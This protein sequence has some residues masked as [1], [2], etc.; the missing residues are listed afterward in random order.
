MPEIKKKSL[1]DKLNEPY[2]AESLPVTAPTTVNDNS[3]VN[4]DGMK[5]N[6]D[7]WKDLG[8]SVK[9]AFTGSKAQ[10]EP[11]KET[12]SP[13][14]EKTASFLQESQ[15]L[16]GPEKGKVKPEDVPSP[17]NFNSFFQKWKSVPTGLTPKDREMFQNKLSQLDQ[18]ML[19]AEQD[20]ADNKNRL[21]WAEAA[22]QLGHAVVQLFAAQDAA[23][24]NWSISGVKFDKNNWESK[25]D[26]A[27]REYDSYKDTISKQQSLVSR[28]LERADDKSERGGR[29]EQKLLERDYFTTQARIQ[30]NS[31]R[32]SAA[33]KSDDAKERQAREKARMYIANYESAED[34]V[35]KLVNE[36]YKDD[37]EKQKLRDE[38]T[39]ALRKNGH[40]GV[41]KDLGEGGQGS[42]EKKGGIL[43]FFQSE[44]YSK[45]QKYISANKKRGVESVYQGYGVAVPQDVREA[46][47]GQDQ[48]VSEQAPSQNKE[49]VS[50]VE[51]QTPDGKTAI[52]D[53][54]TKQF[55]RYK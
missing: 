48:P 11:V 42:V 52:F 13:E 14:D 47:L 29:D 22:E 3:I 6:I 41:S 38:V 1:R 32:E 5:K 30:A 55:L 17:A 4:M 43:G 19:Q 51:R 53:A 27:L 45:M 46:L 25:L 49:P 28:E 10:A 37:K 24:N 34:A 50:E 18:R 9:N 39:D 16:D 44:D 40:I 23:K 21:L 12:V 54:K 2:Q 7:A 8:S 20:Y 15:S 35:S 31:K 33:L 26:R 36:Q